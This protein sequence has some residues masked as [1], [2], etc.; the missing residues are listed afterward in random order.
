MIYYCVSLYYYTIL[1]NI[2]TKTAVVTV[3]LVFLPYTALGKM[4][5]KKINNHLEPP[6]TQ[7]L[8]KI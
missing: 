6:K 2:V 7:Q 4:S 5:N 8:R 1:P 3:Y